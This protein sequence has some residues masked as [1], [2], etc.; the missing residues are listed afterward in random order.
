VKNVSC[1]FAFTS[2]NYAKCYYDRLLFRSCIASRRII[3]QQF[4]GAVQKQVRERAPVYEPIFVR[5]SALYLILRSYI[6]VRRCYRP[7]DTN[8]AG[9]CE[10]HNLVYWNCMI[11][12]FRVLNNIRSLLITFR[13]SNDDHYRMFHPTAIEETRKTQRPYSNRS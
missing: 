10:I 11:L 1:K 4:Y 2:S 12:P 3:C 5:V 7:A 13:L 8:C 9:N 6:S